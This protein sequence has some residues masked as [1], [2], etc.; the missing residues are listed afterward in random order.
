VDDVEA[1]VELIE[2]EVLDI[3]LDVLLNE[4]LELVEEVEVEL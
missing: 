4:V 1:D 3:L 2:L